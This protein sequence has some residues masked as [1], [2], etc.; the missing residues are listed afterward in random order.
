MCNVVAP[1]PIGDTQIPVRR[2]PSLCVFALNQVGLGPRPWRHRVFFIRGRKSGATWSE[3]RQALHVHTAR[4]CQVSPLFTHSPSRGQFLG[5]PHILRRVPPK[6]P[7]IWGICDYDL[8]G[9]RI[10]LFVFSIESLAGPCGS[11]HRA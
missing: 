4:T 9:I 7:Q 5:E 8:G 6:M 3:G 1:P 2:Q 11:C 10:I